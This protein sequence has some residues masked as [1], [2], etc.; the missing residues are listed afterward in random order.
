MNKLPIIVATI[1]L[2]PNFAMAGPNLEEATND[3]CK[4]LEKPYE[5]TRKAMEMIKKAQASGDTSQMVSAQG[6]MMGVLS[7]SSR[8]FATLPKKYPEIDKDDKLKNRVMTMAEKQCPNP[9]GQ[10]S[11]KP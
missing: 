6:E 10:F 9:A 11:K 2:A 1:L 5:Q 8:C 3:V 7:A 4:C